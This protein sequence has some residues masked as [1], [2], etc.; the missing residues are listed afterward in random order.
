V[1]FRTR[2]CREGERG[3]GSFWIGRSGSF[4]PALFLSGQGPEM[5]ARNGATFPFS[6]QIGS[7]CAKIE[8]I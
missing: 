1:G 4:V 8:I 5:K 6:T 7:A 3:A 2:E